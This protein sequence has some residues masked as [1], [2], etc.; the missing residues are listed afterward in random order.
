MTSRFD[1]AWIDE[2]LKNHLHQRNTPLLKAYISAWGLSDSG[3]PRTDNYSHGP[4]YVSAAHG[5]LDALRVL[6][7]VHSGNGSPKSVSLDQRGVSLLHVAYLLNHDNDSSPLGTVHVH[8]R[9]EAGYT[10][11]MCGAHSVGA[12]GEKATGHRARSEALMNFLLDRGA[13]A[14]DSLPSPASIGAELTG[15]EGELSPQAW[16]TVLSRAITR[17]SYGMVKQLHHGV[18][19]QRCLE[20]YSNGPGSW[21]DGVTVRDVTSLRL[22]SRCWN[23]DGVTALLDHGPGRERGLENVSLISC[24]DSMDRLPLHWAAAGSDPAFEPLLPEGTLSH[25]ITGTFEL[26]VPEDEFSISNIINTRDKKGATPLHY[27]VTTHSPMRIIDS[28]GQSVLHRLASSLDGEPIDLNLLDLLLTHGALLDH[29]D[30]NGDTALHIRAKNLRQV[31]VV[32]ALVAR[33]ARVDVVNKKGNTPVHEAMIGALRPRLSWDGK[34]QELASLEDRVHSQDEVP[35]ALLDGIDGL[36]N[37]PNSAGEMPRQ[38]GEE[39][40]RK[41]RMMEGRNFRR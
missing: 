12:V 18:D 22:G 16:P 24:R 31:A 30:Q 41:W 6:L 35:E 34:G 23:V 39:T 38:L 7:D 28:R 32:R 20:Y 3:I 11:I 4:F 33:G 8:E 36:M 14:A 27:A 25:A 5:S 17:P 13:S 21:D 10:P 40:R 1:V 29:A 37:W 19:G 2:T 9:D 26:I 15:E